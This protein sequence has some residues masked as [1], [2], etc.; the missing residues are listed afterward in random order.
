MKNLK[1]PILVASGLGF[2][3]WDEKIYIFHILLLFIF[4]YDFGLCT[5]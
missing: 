4:I 2:G 1:N 5:F 3:A